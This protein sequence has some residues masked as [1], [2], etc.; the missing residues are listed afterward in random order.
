[1][2]IPFIDLK[3]QY[4]QIEKSIQK[5]I[6]RVLE[7]GKFINGP[8]VNEFEESLSLFTSAKH[9]ITCGNGTDALTIALLALNAKASDAVFVPSFTYIASAES[10]A[11]VGATPYFVDVGIDY[12]ICPKSLEVAID[13][14]KKNGH[15]PR[16]VIPVDLFGKPSIS[17]ELDNVV[18]KYDL[19]T[20]YDS[21]QSF[22]SSYNKKRIGNFGDITTTSFFPAKPLGCYGDGGALFTNDDNLANLI[23]SIKNHGMGVHKYE[24]VNIGVNSRLD[25]IQAAILNQ[26]IK[27]LEGEIEKR[28]EIANYYNK[29]LVNTDLILPELSKDNSYAWAQYTVRHKDRDILIKDLN[30]KGIPTAI[31]YPIPL[32]EQKA[33][34]KCNVVSSGIKNT[35]QFCKEVFSLPMSPYL[36][37]ED[38]DFVIKAFM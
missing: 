3:T 19:K 18:K 8:E 20:I 1:M 31:Y 24:H 35:E 12:N 17:R 7:H 5:S 28:N 23:R 16:I 21:A 37:K 38:Q 11:L 32:N 14:A 36:K 6:N 34:N 4:L 15:K 33:Y 10:I 29:A 22:G 13:D 26:K 25:T 9:S 27:L 30:S 2:K